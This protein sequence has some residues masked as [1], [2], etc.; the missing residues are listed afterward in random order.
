[1]LALYLYLDSRQ[2]AQLHAAKAEQ[3]N[4][5]NMLSVQGVLRPEQKSSISVHET[6]VV[7][8][9][10]VEPGASVKKGDPLLRLQNVAGYDGDILATA[11]AY[12]GQD[13]SANFQNGSV[14]Y[15]DIDGLVSSCAAVGTKIYPAQA[16]VTL[17]DF[18]HAL[19]SL[20]VP[21]LYAS[22]LNIGQS[23]EAASV[24][25]HSLIL[26]GKISHVD[27][28]ITEKTNLLTQEP[29][30]FV[31]CTAELLGEYASLRDG[32]SLDVTI[33]T[34]SVREAITVPQA[35][36]RQN[37]TQEY[38]YVISGSGIEMRPVETG[39]YLLSGVQIKH[40][41]DAGEWVLVDDELP[42]DLSY[43]YWV[44]AA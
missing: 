31:K 21:E 14:L 27:A 44:D 13:I 39:Y 32:M 15:A 40:G 6:S 37:E 1:M 8:E 23:V 30:R 29:E 19:I 2:P 22:G 25:D 16:A 3:T 9:A 35:A 10:Y 36:I 34:D 4:I 11:A 33:I 18:S 38:V 42:A 17:V 26:Q 7:L 12:W 41:V 20:E 28:H 43:G 24:S 5:N